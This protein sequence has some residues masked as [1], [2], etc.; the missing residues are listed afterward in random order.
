[1][2][3]LKYLSV[4]VLLV[5]IL[6][7]I[8]IGLLLTPGIQ[9][10]IILEILDQPGTEISIERIKMG[11]GGLEIDSLHFS[12]NGTEIKFNKLKVEL[13][14]ISLL[15]EDNI[16]INHLNVTD[17]TVVFPH[18][19]QPGEIP[20]VE[21]GSNL[22]AE[23]LQ[24]SFILKRMLPAYELIATQPIH[25]KNAFFAHNGRLLL[26]EMEVTTLLKGV[27]DPSFEEIIFTDVNMS[28]RGALLMT[29]ECSVLMTTE[30][31]QLF[32]KT[33]GEFS[34]N[35][36]PCLEQ[37]LLR[38]F[39]NI[40]A[41]KFSL[42]GELELNNLWNTNL[43]LQIEELNLYN[44]STPISIAEFDLTGHLN[45]EGTVNLVVP[46]TVKGTAG[47]SDGNLQLSY[48]WIENGYEVDALLTGNR[49]FLH[50]FILLPTVYQPV[51]TSS[52]EEPVSYIPFLV[53]LPSSSSSRHFIQLPLHDSQPAMEPFW[54]HYSGRAV[55][56]YKRIDI[57]S[58]NYLDNIASEIHIDNDKITIKDCVAVIYESPFHLKGALNFIT[59]S[60]EPYYLE[61]Q[62]QLPNFDTGAYL[63]K[64]EP[65]SRPVLNAVV[66]LTS[67]L[68]ANGRN[69]DDL[70][71]KAQ[72]QINIKSDK[73]IFRAL[74]AAGDNVSTGADLLNAFSSFLGNKVR[75]LRTAD[76]LTDFLCKINFD[77]FR[78]EAIRDK[79]L[80]IHL[81]EFLVKSRD[82]HLTGQ[83]RVSYLEGVPI[84]DQPV[85][86]KTQFSAKNDIA[87]LL[88][89]LTL[90]SNEQD[91]LGYSLGPSFSIKGSLSHPDFS[92]L[93]RIIFR[94][95]S[96]IL[97]PK[98]QQS[99]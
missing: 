39:G 56:E 36:P 52:L 30:N 32:V 23:N 19:S 84:F 90:L 54:S 34:G 73:G 8:G 9:K 4:L 77:T 71:D 28:S 3:A 92:D 1:M 44:S 11:W 57:N 15:T 83:G 78:I 75:E 74:D 26:K 46:F 62:A 6:A 33:K 37:P 45:Q 21:L 91:N 55:I 16:N 68:R 49:L 27:F 22:K 94:A 24:G 76:R 64:R 60:P 20:S 53:N 38:D 5:V 96:G 14:A 48:N 93:Y 43:K 65:N 85:D 31:D 82:I 97:F 69:L 89:E 2:K 42:A 35:L 13:L 18:Q 29:G 59:D 10:K 72:G 40:E 99:N 63:K 81:T 51:E 50:D 61:A 17:L 66:D 12:Q 98:N 80:D 86:I 95:S 47:I 58:E 88:Q 67:D 87:S 70:L 41:G 7:G 79:N 25:F